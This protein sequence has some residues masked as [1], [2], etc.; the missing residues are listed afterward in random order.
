MAGVLTD[1]RQS[2]PTWPNRFEP[3]S[4]ISPRHR[5]RARHAFA[6]ALSPHSMMFSVSKSFCSTRYWMP[7]RVSSR[8]QGK[9]VASERDL[10]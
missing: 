4:S 7:A 9:A 10:W 3:K 5:A 2:E 8:G 6:P 1:W